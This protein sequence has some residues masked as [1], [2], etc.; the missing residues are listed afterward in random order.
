MLDLKRLTVFRQVA[1]RRSFSAA[2]SDL[3]YSQPAVSHHI[4]RLEAELGVTLLQRGGPNGVS[5]TAAGRRLFDHASALLERA[6][7]AEAEL[8][9]LAAREET[10]R[11]AAFQTAAATIVVEAIAALR[12][13]PDVPNVVLVEAEAQP[14][15]DALRER[16]V[17]LALVF[18]DLRHPLR[19]PEGI[20]V[21]Y[22]FDDPFLMAL[23]TSHPLADAGTLSVAQLRDERWIQGAGANTAC[24]RILL[25]VCDQASFRPQI[26]GNSGNFDVV[27]ELVAAGVG[28][29]LVPRLAAM[30]RP[31]EGI[32]CCELESPVPSRRVALA[33]RWTATPAPPALNATERA[34]RHSAGRW[35]ARHTSTWRSGAPD[36]RR[37]DR[38]RE[39]VALHGRARRAGESHA[40]SR[41]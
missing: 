36:V 33:R 30:R 3:N 14:T 19:A 23:P 25:D 1:L 17:D 4:G 24:T 9:L 34:L 18:D 31:V 13:D 32:V 26:A 7:S 20:T 10:V 12:S 6:Q 5:L 28:I 22:L 15:L 8:G 29:A 37:A 2:A 21:E 38:R 41:S 11:L 40:G 27:L 39:G 35:A 16:A